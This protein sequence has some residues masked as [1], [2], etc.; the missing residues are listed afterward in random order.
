LRKHSQFLDDEFRVSKKSFAL[1]YCRS[2]AKDTPVGATAYRSEYRGTISVS[3]E[4]KKI[5]ISPGK[6]IGISQW[7]GV[8]SKHVVSV[9]AEQ[10]WN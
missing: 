4:R 6:E 2:A 3:V 5:S 8:G 10:S 7:L 9:S 1:P